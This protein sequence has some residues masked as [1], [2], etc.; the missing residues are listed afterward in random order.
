MPKLQCNDSSS[1]DNIK[2][3]HRDDHVASNGWHGACLR[4]QCFAAHSEAA[5]QHNEALQAGKLNPY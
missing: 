5:D 3:D 2:S 4:Q 1:V